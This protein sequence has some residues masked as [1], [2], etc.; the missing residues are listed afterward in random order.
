MSWPMF[1]VAAIFLT[2]GFLYWFYLT[3]SGVRARLRE[4]I[5]REDGSESLRSHSLQTATDWLI[6]RKVRVWKNWN[7]TRRAA[8][9]SNLPRETVEVYEGRCASAKNDLERLYE[10]AKKG[11]LSVFALWGTYLERGLDTFPPKASV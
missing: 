7:E 11:K 6:A 2:F 8:T 4:E 10:L 1:L 9:A 5:K 3:P